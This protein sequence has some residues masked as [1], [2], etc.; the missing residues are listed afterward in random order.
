MPEGPTAQESPDGQRRASARRVDW[1]KDLA[2][3]RELFQGYRQWIVDHRDPAPSAESRVR[4][5]LAMIDELLAGLPGTYRPPRGDVLLWFENESVVA[6][7]ALRQ[8]EAK[9]GEIKRIYVRADYRGMEF[10]PVFVRTIIG[11]ARELGLTRL[12][13]D[14]LPT[15]SAAIEFYQQLGFRPIPAFWPHPAAGALFFESDIGP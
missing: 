13:V 5:G 7:G 3:V 15:M 1:S 2:T 11:R 12:R 8:L 9:V 4:E 6:C 10:G 14:T